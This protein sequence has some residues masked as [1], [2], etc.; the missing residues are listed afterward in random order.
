M[1]FVFS[2]LL[3]VTIITKYKSAKLYSFFKPSLSGLI[4]FIPIIY[5]YD[6]SESFN[7]FIVLGL[8]ASFVGDVFLL[9]PEKYF[10]HGLLAFLCAHIIYSISFAIRINEFSLLLAV[11]YFFV[12]LF[13]LNVF[14]EALNFSIVI[15]MF[16]ITLMGLLA[17]NLWLNH[18]NT[19][20]NLIFTGSVLFMISDFT[21]AYNKF[22]KRFYLAEFIIL[23]SYF[24]AQYLFALSTLK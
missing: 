23:T 13:I 19:V 10:K 15:Y 21:L 16:M 3:V 22:K 9:K 5:S 14:R 12:L 17:G 1:E 11:I 24:I 4:I 7:Q 2:A 20:S 8:I 18:S 6:L